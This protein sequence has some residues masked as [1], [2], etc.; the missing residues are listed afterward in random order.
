MNAEELK[1]TEGTIEQPINSG[2]DKLIKQ[3]PQDDIKK[4]FK[5]IKETKTDKDKWVNVLIIGETGV[6]K[7]TLINAIFGREIAEIGSGK[8]VTQEIEAYR[9]EE[10]RLCIY[11]TKGLEIKDS[12]TISNIEDFIEAQEQKETSEQIHIALLCIQEASRRVQEAHI[13]LY[14]NLQ[15]HYFP[16]ILVITK[17]QC[18]TDENGEKFSDIVKKEFNISDDSIQ[19]VRALPLIDEDTGKVLQDRQGIDDL[20]KKMYD[21]MDEGHRN[22]FGRK[23]RYDKEMRKKVLKEEALSVV[24]QHSILAAGVAVSPIPFSDIAALL[25]IQ[26]AMIG[27]I[28][29]T[30]DIFNLD[31]EN[32]KKMAIAFAGVCGLGFA[33]RLAVGNLVKFIPFLGSVAGAAINGFVANATTKVMGNTYV[34]YLDN[35]YDD[36]LENGFD[37][38]S[39]TQFFK[40]NEDSIA[41]KA[42]EIVES[43]AKKS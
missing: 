11:D 5:E 8:P 40:D 34:Q 20:I 30:Y 41:D 18:D 31:S 23:Q 6:G 21:K 19:R 29:K 43:E 26:I 25:P 7:S 24:K 15:S 35:N 13:D 1:Q 17:A 16:T 3:I 2:I 37:I 9:N 28:S 38:D 22:A 39:V 12:S 36:I 42:K 32:I 14:N 27:R 33:T 4:A 10:E